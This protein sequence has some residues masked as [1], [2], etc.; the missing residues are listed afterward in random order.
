MKLTLALTALLATT[1][2]TIH[3]NLR[4]EDEL[5]EGAYR[6]RSVKAGIVPVEEEDIVSLGDRAIKADSVP[7]EEK[8][9]VCI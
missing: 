6:R 4:N 1:A 8:D 5:F 7:V 2:S 3:L 9:I